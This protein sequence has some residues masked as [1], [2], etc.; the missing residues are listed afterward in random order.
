[1]KRVI[2]CVPNFSEGQRKD[3]IDAIAH[4]VATIPGVSLLDV[5]FGI[6]TNRTIYT[7]VGHPQGV[8]EAALAAARV[9][10]NLIDMTKHVGEHPRI[11]AMD[12]VPFVPVRNAT[13]ADCIDLAREF[14]MRLALEFHIPV[15]LY[16]EAQEKEYRKDLAQIREGEYEGL[17]HKIRQQEWQPDF[18]PSEFV[19]SWGAT[20]VGARKSLIAFNINLLGTKEQ[21]YRI[22]ANLGQEGRATDEPGKL[23]CVRSLGWWSL[24][25][26]LAQ[27]SLNLTDFEITNIHVAYEQCVQEAELLNLGVCGSQI[28]GIVPLKSLLLAADYFIQKE[29]LFVLEEDQK[30]RLVIQRL[31]LNS[32]TPF[33]PKERIIEYII[34]EREGQEDSL[35]SME[36]KD[37]IKHVGARNLIPGGGCV[38]SLVATFGTALSTMCASF[39]YGMQ[40]CESVENEIRALIV[41]FHTAISTLM[42]TLDEDTDAFNSFLMVQRMAETS[43]EEKRFKRLTEKHCLQNCLDISL[44]I[45]QQVNQL[46]DP[47]RKLALLFNIQ[48]KADFLMAIKCLETAVYGACKRL[49]FLSSS[50]IDN[51]NDTSDSEVM[52]I[53]NTYLKT[54]TKLLDDAQRESQSILTFVEERYF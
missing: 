42:K 50:L 7:F 41:L 49:E 24:E 39:S 47:L 12:V 3:V 20:C 33:S 45:A 18:G 31:G 8:V 36:L 26:N 14:A 32:I 35:T 40:K 38:T 16:G 29:N 21:A 5:D 51:K 4:A 2:E 11:G 15:Y 54:A 48:T 1:M 6:A 27:V 25:G 13:M 17:Y 46:W 30:I 44:D 9:A 34:R 19:P 28:I 37:L 23:K 22:A 52:T 10:H 43:V 53:R